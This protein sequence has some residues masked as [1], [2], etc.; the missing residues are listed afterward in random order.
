MQAKITENAAE[1]IW[2]EHARC[3]GSKPRTTISDEL[4]PT[5]DNLQAEFECS[6]VFEDVPSHEGVIRMLVDKIGLPT[7][8]ERL[9]EPYQRALFLSWVTSHFIY[10][11]GMNGS[12]VDFFHFARDLASKKK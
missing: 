8:L 9:P 11:Y 2:R 10:K 12:S 1:C 3:G 4:S 7:L 6:H 5:L